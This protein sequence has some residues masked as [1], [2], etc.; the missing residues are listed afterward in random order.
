MSANAELAE[1]E[2]ELANLR[3]A[4]QTHGRTIQAHERKRVKAAWDAGRELRRAKQIVGHGGWLDW[5]RTHGWAQRTVNDYM[6]LARHELAVFADLGLTPAVERARLLSGKGA[7]RGSTRAPRGVRFLDVWRADGA[8]VIAGGDDN[9]P[10]PG[11]VRAVRQALS[12]LEVNGYSLKIVGS[13]SVGPQVR[14]VVEV[15]PNCNGVAA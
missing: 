10:P 15:E 7:P 13:G 1:I 12:T 3:E 9:P 8:R 6:A 2:A 5:L 14:L 11:A 4:I